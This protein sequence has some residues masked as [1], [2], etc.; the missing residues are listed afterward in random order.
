[1]AKELEKL[2]EGLKVEIH[3]NLLRTTPK[4]YQIGKHQTMMEYMDF[5]F[6]KIH[7]HSQQT[8]MLNEQ[9]STRSTCTL[10]EDQRKDHIDLE[11][12]P[13]RNCSKHLQTHYLPT[14]DVENSK[15][16]NKGRDLLLNNKP[17]IVH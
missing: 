3:I 15:S 16:I 4:K 17:W 5:E 10:M 13:Q 1:M 9:M 8:N 14:D 7:L 2:E 6:K 11:G 12:P